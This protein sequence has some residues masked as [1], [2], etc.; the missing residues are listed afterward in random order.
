VPSDSRHF[1]VTNV[2]VV[3]AKAAK[4]VDVAEVKGRKLEYMKNHVG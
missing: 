3:A 4:G 1:S 2:W